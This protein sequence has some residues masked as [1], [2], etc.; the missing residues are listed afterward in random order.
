MD[1]EPACNIC[2]FSVVE[3][4]QAIGCR[5]DAVYLRSNLH[6][7]MLIGRA[8]LPINDVIAGGP[9]FQNEQP[10]L[11]FTG[12]PQR[13]K[14]VHDNREFR[15]CPR[16]RYA[17]HVSDGVKGFRRIRIRLGPQRYVIPPDRRTAPSVPLASRCCISF[18]G[19]T[20]RRSVLS[21][22]NRFYGNGT[23]GVE[24]A[25]GQQD[26]EIVLGIYVEQWDWICRFSPSE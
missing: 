10:L 9:G 16:E 11:P 26:A 8:I 15:L 17:S 24:L 5:L 13:I 14:L 22:L 3:K 12:I 19:L 7:Y 1:I 23:Y 4:T 18:A 20:G 25:G 21:W 2:R 6:R